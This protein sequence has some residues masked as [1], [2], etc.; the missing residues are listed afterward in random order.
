MHIRVI[1][2]DNYAMFR[3]G[4]AR[5][6]TT[7]NDFQL[8]G[9]YDDL[10]RLYKAV[11]TLDGAIVIFSSSLE[12]SLPVLMSKVNGHN[13]RF[14]AVLDKRESSQAYRRHNIDGIIYRDVSQNEAHR[15]LKA[16]AAGN[17]Y[18]QTETSA[19]P[20]ELEIVLVAPEPILVV[21]PRL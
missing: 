13:V 21:R 6:L 11:E 3:A 18:T 14:V 1:I 4:F 12:P 2:A 9:Q 5:F 7:D 16:V 10:T 19:S 8:V 17:K 15:C 20:E